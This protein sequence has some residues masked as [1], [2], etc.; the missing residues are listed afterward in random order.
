SRSA[1]TRRPGRRLARVHLGPSRSWLPPHLHPA[2]SDDEELVQLPSR[3]GGQRAGGSPAAANMVAGRAANAKRLGRGSAT[4]LLLSR[5]GGRTSR[6]NGPR[7]SLRFVEHAFK[8]AQE[9]LP[10]VHRAPTAAIR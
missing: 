7:E 10:C 5:L 6:T 8:V 9:E 2:R 3:R 4:S 1:A